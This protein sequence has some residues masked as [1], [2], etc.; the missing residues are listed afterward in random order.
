MKQLTKKI[1]IEGKIIAESGIMV[2]GSSSAMDIGGADKQVVRNP[3]TNLPYIPGS[4]LKGKMRSLLELIMGQLGEDRKGN[5]GPTHDP[6]H[7]PARIFGFIKSKEQNNNEHQQPS[8]LI[9]RDS[10]LINPDKL[11]N[12]ELPYTEITAENTIARITAAANP[13]FFERVPKGAEFSLNMVLNVFDDEDY[14]H[15]VFNALRLVQD[16]YIGGSGSRGNGQVS[17]KIKSITQR[18]LSYYEN[19]AK[20]NSEKEYEL[21][22]PADFRIQ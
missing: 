21:D 4:S 16:D 14:L 7:I 19:K 22:V 3:I 5:T 2:G 18:N 11:K 13:R 8:R 6:K 20:G 1:I 10:E 15:H 9:V 12:T 17:F